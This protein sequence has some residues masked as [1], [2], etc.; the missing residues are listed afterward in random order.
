VT[1]IAFIVTGRHGRQTPWSKWGHVH[2]VLAVGVFPLLLVFFQQASLIA[3]LANSFSVPWVGMLVVPVALLGTAFMPWSEGVGHALIELAVWLMDCVWPL[4]ERLAAMEGALW[5]QHQPL[6]WTVVPALAGVFLLFAPRGLPGRWLGALL[7]LPLFLAKPARPLT[8]EVWVSLLDVGQGLSTVVQT[9]N[10]TLVYDAGPRFSPT[11]DTGRA[12]L[13]PFLRHQ[14]IPRVD[15]LIV[16]H[17][18]NDHIGGVASLLAEVPVVQLTAGIPAKVTERSSDPCTRGDNWRWDGV[19]FRVLAPDAGA[20][21]KGN[22]ASCVLRISTQ[23]GQ[24][25]LLTGDI[26][27]SV[28]RSLLQDEQAQLPADVL[29]VPHHGSLTSSSPSFIRAVD[30]EY[31]LFPAGYRNRYRFPR[32]EV[33]ERYRSS[34]AQLYETGR[35]GTITARMAPGEDLHVLSHRVVARRYWQTE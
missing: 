32:P 19:G 10:H 33:V 23:D 17:G 27:E 30:P 5:E 26:E 4:L 9:R 18:D 14:G 28:E 29:V 2:V 24:A 15:R 6:A 25:V 34:G 16:S 31:A 7:L 12:V 22:N 11:F 1:M 21:R 35:H 13:V 8:G 3:P 20:R